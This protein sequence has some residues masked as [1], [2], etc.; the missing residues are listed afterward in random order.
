M[1]GIPVSFMKN[2][3]AVQ[4]VC[5]FIGIDTPAVNTFGGDRL[6]SGN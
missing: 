1:D 5:D 6:G 4:S 2:P 3:L